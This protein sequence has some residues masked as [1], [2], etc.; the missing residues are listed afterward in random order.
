MMD[1]T[2][3]LLLISLF[4]YTIDIIPSMV[5]SIAPSIYNPLSDAGNVIYNATNIAE[6]PISA[7]SFAAYNAYKYLPSK[8]IT[9]ILNT[10]SR[11]TTPLING[12]PNT[13]EMVPNTAENNIDNSQNE[14]NGA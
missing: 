9:S 6:I 5:E 8:A 1:I 13:L 12:A 4:K 7:P 14:R 3:D 11:N 2:T 10:V